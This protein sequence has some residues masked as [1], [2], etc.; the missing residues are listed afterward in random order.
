MLEQ[1]RPNEPDDGIVVGEDAD[2][3]C[4][5]LDLAVETLDRICNRYKT[6]GGDVLLQF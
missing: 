6:S 5:S 3:F 4:A 2:D 1:Q